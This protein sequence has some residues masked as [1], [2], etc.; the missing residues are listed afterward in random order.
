[1]NRSNDAQQFWDVLRLA[2]P[3]RTRFSLEH[4]LENFRQTFPHR[5]GDTDARFVLATL[6]GELEQSGSIRLPNKTN[7]RAYD[8]SER[9]SLPKHVVRCDRP[10]RVKQ[11]SLVWRPELAFAPEVGSSLQTELFAIQEWFRNGGTTAVFVA[12]RER[13]VEIFGDE[14]RLDSLLGSQLFAPGRLTLELLRCYLPS[15]PIYVVSVPDDGA[16]RPLLVVENHTTFDTLCRWNEKQRLY[17]AIAFGA[18]AAFIAACES[19]RPHLIA[20]GCSGKL[21]YFG[22]LDP[23]GLWIPARASKDSGIEVQ[24][25]ETLY[26]LLLLKNSTYRGPQGDSFLF[27]TELLN[28]LPS[29][30]REEVKQCFHRGRRL[31]QELV[32]LIDLTCG[33]LYPSST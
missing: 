13:S 25:D 2:H 28:W 18:G 23:K 16:S 27:D 6:L 11:S 8:H 24:P 33:V 29:T 26:N 21:L 14:K 5:R 31:P 3:H 17:S 12:L 20:P 10:I 9:T 32:S 1:M 22:D 30:F 7:R 4:L 19:L 15:V